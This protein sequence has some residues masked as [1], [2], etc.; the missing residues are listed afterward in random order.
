MTIDSGDVQAWIVDL[1][2]PG[3]AAGALDAAERHRAEGYLRPLDGARFAASRMAT[4]VILSGYAGYAPERLRFCTDERGRPRLAGHRLC[5][6]LTR[7]GGVAVIVVAPEPVGADV[8]LMRARAGLTDLA[9]AWFGAAEAGCIAAGCAGSPVRGF[10]WHWTVKEAYLKA[11][12]CGL[13]ELRNA[14]FV[15]GPEPFIR[16]RGAAESGWALSVTDLAGGY[17]AAIAAS[18]PVTSWRRLAG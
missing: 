4:R 3:A 17:V 13:A 14:E 12:G 11:V 5:F 1:D 18:R 6:S 15:C 10:Y 2:R 8:E 16:F 9:T 7:S